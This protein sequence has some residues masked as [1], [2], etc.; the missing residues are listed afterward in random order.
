MEYK[1]Q[2][3]VQ[4]NNYVKATILKDGN[5][6]DSRIF[7]YTDCSA[8]AFVFRNETKQ[9]ESR[10]KMAHKWADEYIVQLK[11]YEE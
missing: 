10:F 2:I 11:K 8:W 6:V 1:K 5:Q 3:L 4:A 9:R 7:S